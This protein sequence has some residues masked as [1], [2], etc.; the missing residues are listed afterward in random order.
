MKIFINTMY[1]GIMEKNNGTFTLEPA[2]NQGYKI[3]LTENEY[4]ILETIGSQFMSEDELIRH[5]ECHDSWG[6]KYRS[7]LQGL[8]MKRI[9]LVGRS[10]EREKAVFKALESKIIFPRYVHPIKA[11]VKVFKIG[12]KDKR[13]RILK[14]YKLLSNIVLSEGGDIAVIA[15]ALSEYE[16]GEISRRKIRP[17]IRQIGEGIRSFGQYLN[18]EEQMS[19]EDITARLVRVV[20][21]LHSFRVIVIRGS[22]LDA[23]HKKNLTVCSHIY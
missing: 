6:I 13:R 18:L 17:R 12:L 5:V 1:D 21:I 23:T 19:N 14:Q 16:N 9:I 22:L 15:K 11:S 10:N 20:G 7:A 4:T 8:V 2:Y 3:Y